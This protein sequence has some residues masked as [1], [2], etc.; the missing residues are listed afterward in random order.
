MR[1]LFHSFSSAD[2][3]YFSEKSASGC[4]V[5][6]LCPVSEIFELTEKEEGGRAMNNLSKTNP[7]ALRP[8]CGNV[9]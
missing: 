9:P 2:A 8:L 7:M 3:E 6:N 5:D 1:A 4:C